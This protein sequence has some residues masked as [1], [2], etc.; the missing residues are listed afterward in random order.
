MKGSE[1]L[2]LLTSCIDKLEA[3]GFKEDRQCLMAQGR[4]YEDFPFKPKPIASL[5]K[6]KAMFILTLGE[7]IV[8]RDFLADPK[9]EIK[10]IELEVM[11][12]SSRTAVDQRTKVLEKERV[13]RMVATQPKARRAI[14]GRGPAGGRPQT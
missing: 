8:L 9:N 6:G 5:P 14:F 3:E 2:A 10:G 1:L 12:K 13:R 11:P 4:W 7:G